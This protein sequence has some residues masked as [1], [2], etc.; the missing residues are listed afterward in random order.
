MLKSILK[1]TALIV[2]ILIGWLAPA[3]ARELRLFDLAGQKSL[4]GPEAME[5][6]RN[7]R[8]VLV[9]EHHDRAE[10]HRAQLQVIKALHRSGRRV[11]VGLEMFRRDSQA[12]LDRWVNGETSEDRFTPIYLDNWNYGWGLY[13]PIFDYARLQ[14]IPMAGLN[15]SR[16]LTTQV[17][18][19]GFESLNAGQKGSLEGIS[20]DVTAAYRNFVRQAYGAYGHKKLDFGRFCEAQ[21]VWDA[22]MA[23]HAVDY[24]QKRPDTVLIILAGSGHA[25]KLGIPAQLAKRTSWPIAVLLPETTG[26]FDP[27]HTSVQDADYIILNE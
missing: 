22:A 2:V 20:C 9:G 4:S 11:A 12:D 5:R 27:E 18:T 25:R 17:A 19:Q 1:M 8:F 13:R 23:M 21:L 24:L 7:V 6:L 16:A 10:H 14:K 15:V 26:I 3:D